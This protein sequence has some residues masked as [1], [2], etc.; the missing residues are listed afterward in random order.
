VYRRELA[1]HA[2]VAG[3]QEDDACTHYE[4]RCER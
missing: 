2:V 1:R 4:K 3:V